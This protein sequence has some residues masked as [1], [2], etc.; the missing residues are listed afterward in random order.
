MSVLADVLL[1]LT[2]ARQRIGDQDTINDDEAVIHLEL[3]MLIMDVTLLLEK[4]KREAPTDDLFVVNKES[5]K[6]N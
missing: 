5:L 6:W 1:L 4:E 3:S 2:E